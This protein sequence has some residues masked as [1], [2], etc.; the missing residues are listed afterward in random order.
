MAWIKVIAESEAAGKLKQTYDEQ[1]KLAGGVANILKIHSLA[2]HILASHLGLYKAIMR[3][4]GAIPQR[5][6]EMIAVRVS[7]QEG[8]TAEV[9]GRG[10]LRAALTSLNPVTSRP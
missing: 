6:R 10:R 1:A 9:E 3:T 4:P 2:P 7:S 8:G 5:L